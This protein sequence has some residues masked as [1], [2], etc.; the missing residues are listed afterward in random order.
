M[1]DSKAEKTPRASGV[2]YVRDGKEEK[3]RATKEVI[4]S[5]GAIGSPQLLMLSGIGPKNHLEEVGV[6]KIKVCC[7]CATYCWNELNPSGPVKSVTRVRYLWAMAVTSNSVS[8]EA[9]FVNSV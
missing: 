4:L 6:S 8:Y 3:V 7:S 1:I 9:I 2:V 5:A